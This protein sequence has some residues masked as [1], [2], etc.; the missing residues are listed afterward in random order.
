MIDQ[1]FQFE[2]TFGFCIWDNCIVFV[3]RVKSGVASVGDRLAF[4]ANGER[5][6]GTIKAIEN[7]RELIDQTIS[8]IEI[9]VGLYDFS[10][11][12]IDNAL[13]HPV[14]PNDASVERMGV[15]FPVIL[16]ES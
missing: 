14:N 15:S 9:G 12:T 4:E 10:D 11:P 2:S 13:K 5:V 3:G 16:S 7:D 8:G 1:P 6:T